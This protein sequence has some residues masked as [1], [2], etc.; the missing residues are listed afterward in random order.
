MSR[1]GDLLR[2]VLPLPAA[3]PDGFVAMVAHELDQFPDQHDRLVIDLAR[4]R[5]VSESVIRVGL[6]DPDGYWWQPVRAERDYSN[7]R[8]E[9]L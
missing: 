5:G 7:E 6:H 8:G 2:S 9:R 4:A 3:D 1:D